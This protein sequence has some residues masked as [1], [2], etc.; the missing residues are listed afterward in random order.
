MVEKGLLDS[1]IRVVVDVYGLLSLTGKG[2]YIDIVIIMGFVGNE[3]V[4]VDIDSI[5][6]FIRDVEERER[7][8]LV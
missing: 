6:G 7:L 1:V 5:F 2:Y 3:F 4:I 8:L